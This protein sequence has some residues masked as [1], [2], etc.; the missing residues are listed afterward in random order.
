LTRLIET[1]TPTVERSPFRI[2]SL[3]VP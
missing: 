1:S 2:R 3:T